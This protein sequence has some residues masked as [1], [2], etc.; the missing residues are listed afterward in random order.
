[1]C[2]VD[3]LASIGFQQFQ[4]K[5]DE[6]L[7]WV[8]LGGFNRL[9]TSFRMPLPWRLRLRWMTYVTCVVWVSHGTTGISTIPDHCSSSVGANSRS[10]TISSWVVAWR[11]A[12][13]WTCSAQWHGGGFSCSNESPSLVFII[14]WTSRLMLLEMIGQGSHEGVEPAADLGL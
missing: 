7:A 11:G 9:H 8:G 2:L 3:G 13:L 12:H 14:E 5:F 4:S 6:P 10:I 1:M